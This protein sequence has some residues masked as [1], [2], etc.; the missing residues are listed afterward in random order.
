[1]ENKKNY[2]ENEFVKNFLSVYA[3]NNGRK[4][5]EELLN[6]TVGNNGFALGQRDTLT[7]DIKIKETEIDGKKQTFI[8][9]TTVNGNE[10]SLMSLMSVSSLKGYELT[11]AVDVE[12]D[13]KNTKQTR[14]V[15]SDLIEEFDFADVWQP[16]SRNLL[17]LAAMIADK[18]VNLSG[19]TVTFLGTAVKP[20]I[21]KK[22]GDATFGEAYK[23]GYKRAIETKLWKID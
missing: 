3:A 16:K 5:P 13:V 15:Q 21:A 23:K 9:L 6:R 19:K 1:M 14:S 12:F 4:S 10:F 22:D 2:Q 11:D 8:V 7:G 17:E 20:F 18:E